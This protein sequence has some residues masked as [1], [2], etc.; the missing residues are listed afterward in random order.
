M[1]AHSATSGTIT[2]GCHN[3]GDAVWTQMQTL[4][5]EQNID[6]TSKVGLLVELHTFVNICKQEVCICP[7]VLFIVVTQLATL[8][9]FRSECVLTQ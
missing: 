9:L 5:A 3:T 1:C 6:F 2:L 4:E 7:Y 8:I